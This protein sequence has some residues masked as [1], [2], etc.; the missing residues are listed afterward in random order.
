MSLSAEEI[1]RY[2]RDGFLVVEDV[3]APAEIAELRRVTDALV[4][5]AR[6]VTAHT[7]VYDL[8]PSY[9]TWSIPCSTARCA[10]RA[11]SRS[12]AICS[13]RRCASM[14]PSST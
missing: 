5:N 12:C 10:T 1:A 3:L 13:G 11:S 9:R 14:N 6:T 4:E 7:G 2:R 8:E